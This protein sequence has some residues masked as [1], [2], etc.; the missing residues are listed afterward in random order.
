MESSLESRLMV[1]ERR[2]ARW[3]LAGLLVVLAVWLAAVS[4]VLY[5]TVSRGAVTV[6][7]LMLVDDRGERRAVLQVQPNGGAFF[8][9]YDR[10]GRE[11]AAMGVDAEGRP[12]LGVLGQDE[13]P[14][15]TLRMN[16][17]ELPEINLADADRQLRARL[18]W[19]EHGAPKLMTFA[20][21]EAPPPA[22]K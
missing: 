14:R 4:A 10:L 12:A 21:G 3:R 8:L 20:P 1:L 22:G 6:E 9:F 2:L 15:M 16:E 19:D 17:A 5:A 13:K 7:Q 18:G 11:R